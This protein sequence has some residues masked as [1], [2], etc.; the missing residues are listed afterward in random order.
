[1]K[2]NTETVKI[3]SA[4]PVLLRLTFL[5]V[6]LKE[7]TEIVRINNVP[8]CSKKANILLLAAL[9]LP[10]LTSFYTVDTGFQAVFWKNISDRR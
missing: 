2:E 8:S 3:N 4:A 9:T 7:S 10:S 1:L 6:T 5:Y